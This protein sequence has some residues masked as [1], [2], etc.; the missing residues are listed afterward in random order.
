MYRQNAEARFTNSRTLSGPSKEEEKR[1]AEQRRHKE[2]GDCYGLIGSLIKMDDYPVFDHGDNIHQ[3]HLCFKFWILGA[4]WR[5]L[6][7]GGLVGFLFSTLISSPGFV[8]AGLI[9]NA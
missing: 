1:G 6:R 2:D 9:P 7:G 5:G 8:S 4:E 3:I